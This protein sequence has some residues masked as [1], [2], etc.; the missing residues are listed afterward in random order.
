MQDSWLTPIGS[1]LVFV[2]TVIILIVTHPFSSFINKGYK[3][4]QKQ[5][6]S[7]DVSKA[8]LK[9]NAISKSVILD[10]MTHAINQDLEPIKQAQICPTFVDMIK[11]THDTF[12]TRTLTGHYRNTYDL[13]SPALKTVNNSNFCAGTTKNIG[14]DASVIT[15]H[16]HS[17]LEAQETVLHELTHSICHRISNLQSFDKNEFNAR[18]TSKCM[19]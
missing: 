17:R 3:Q 6:G 2:L 12:K 19:D 1:F 4:A 11:Q 8:P 10:E 7:T 15:F 9:Q 18:K 13:K 14:K 16:G 5:L